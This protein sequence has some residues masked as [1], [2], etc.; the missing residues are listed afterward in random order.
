MKLCNSDYCALANTIKTE[1]L[2]VIIYGVGMIGRIIVPYLIN[3]YG[4]HTYIDCFIDAD[5]RKANQKINIDDYQ[6]EIRTPDY[7]DIIDKNYV[8]LI[9]NSKFFSVVNFLDGISNL[10]DIKGYIVPMMQIYELEHTESIEI[11]PVSEEQLIPK[12]IHYCWFG[13]KEKPVFLQNCIESWKKYCPD[14]EF[15]EWNET[16]YDVNRHSYTKEAYEKGQY[17]FVT[18]M[19]RLDILYENGGIY[20]DTDVNL[21]TS[22]D[23]LLFQNGF[24]GTEKWGNI[25]SGGGCGFVKHHPML[26]RII[27]YRDKFHFVLPDDSLNIETCGMYESKVFIEA[28]FKPNNRLQTISGITVYPSYVNH[29]YDYMSCEMHK[30][31]ATISVHHFYG[32]W[33]DEEDRLNR[34]NT[35]EQYAAIKERMIND[36]KNQ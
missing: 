2:K 26:K 24:I 21:E 4:L 28:G 8:V 29:P 5:K 36:K 14:Y 35:Q 34:R 12:T 33:M 10:N 15:I 27:E 3:E 19:A 23:H 18:D 1:N 9:T 16:S 13:K 6:Y 25:N 20:F 17:G 7:L 30:K 22:L 31:R 32:G 11:N